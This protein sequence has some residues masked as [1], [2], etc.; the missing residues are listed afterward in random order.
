M[1]SEE[2]SGY[3]DLVKKWQEFEHSHT[4]RSK[5]EMF[6]FFELVI[7]KDLINFVAFTNSELTISKSKEEITVTLS[8]VNSLLLSCDEDK[9]LLKI[10]NVANAVFVRKNEK[11]KNLELELWFRGWEWEE[12]SGESNSL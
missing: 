7:K 4:K 5:K 12:N 8:E 11:S 2:N 10:M 3:N 9:M 6:K 1:R